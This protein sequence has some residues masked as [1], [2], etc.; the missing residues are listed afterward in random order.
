MNIHHLRTALLSAL[1]PI[2][3]RVR[4][5]AARALI[6]SVDDSQA[7]QKVQVSVLSGERLAEVLRLQGFGHTAVPPAN[8]SAL[9]L[10][11]GGSRTRPV[12]LGA[13]W[14]GRPKGL[15]AG[16]SA[17][18][19]AIEQI[20]LLRDDGTIYVKANSKVLVEAPEAEFTGNVKING[21]LHIVGNT[22]GDGTG[23]FALALSSD[24]S[25]S[26]PNRSM[27]Q[28]AST[29]NA[30]MHPISGGVAQPTAE[31]VP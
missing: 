3:R 7:V 21:N 11:L 14:L 13:D 16:E 26:D 17:L 24:T 30:H 23:H 10:S 31:T 19:D 18:Y 28:L 6:T 1:A 12:V 29:H 8:C 15:K 2:E 5:M 27:Q 20:V 22:S 4:S 25:V 9:L